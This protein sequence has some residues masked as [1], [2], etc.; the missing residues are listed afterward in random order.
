[1]EI[2]W[3]SL[4]LRLAYVEAQC[5]PPDG[6]LYAIPGLELHRP[7]IKIVVSAMLSITGELAKLPPSVR[8]ASPDLPKQWTARSIAQAV[9]EYHAS[10]AHLFGKDRGIV[11][12]HTD[13]TLLMTVLTRMTKKNIPLLPLHDAV[14]CP[15]SAKDIA[16]ATMQE[17]S[18]EL[19]GVTLPVSLKG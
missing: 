17:A 9:K 8:E 11:Y 19:L 16:I 1:M 3:Q 18:R 4:H 14:L 6:D 15:A 10:I 5:T 7:A 2:D 13:A 12:M